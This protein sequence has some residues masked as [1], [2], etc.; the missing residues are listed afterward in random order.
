[1]VPG[2]A[3]VDEGIDVLFL[4]DPCALVSVEERSFL[5]L[6]LAQVLKLSL[7]IMSLLAL[8]SAHHSVRLPVVKGA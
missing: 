4:L 7:N 6:L 2:L 3:E 1:V 5:C 8:L